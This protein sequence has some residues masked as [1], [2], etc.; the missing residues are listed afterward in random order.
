MPSQRILQL[1]EAMQSSLPVV[2]PE[3]GILLVD[4]PSGPTSHDVI[5]VVRHHFGIKKVG[6]A[7][8][9]DPLA[10]GLLIVLVGKQAT[11][12]AQEFVG[13]DKEYEVT[14]VL[15]EARDTY[16][17]EGKTTFQV[18]GQQS[19]TGLNSQQIEAALPSFRG[20]TQQRVPA[21]SA[22][23][24]NGKPLYRYAREGNPI[25]YDQL[26]VKTIRIH[27][28]DILE[29]IPGSAAL[30]QVR[31]RVACSK[32]TFIRSL[33]HDLG[34]M[35]NVGAYVSALRRT[36]VGEYRLPHALT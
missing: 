34:Q 18:E 9:L 25:P 31:L 15:G 7:G 27:Q 20:E 12:R 36:K 28:L 16:D 3:D 1:H 32:G 2:P 8:T 5:D 13:L 23:K 6:H 17:A 10:S 11:R 33:I 29:F 35:L 19:L 22:V 30:P 14:G 24:L 21:Y 26:P 4:K